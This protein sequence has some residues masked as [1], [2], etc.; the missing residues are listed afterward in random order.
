MTAQVFS[1]LR[2]FAAPRDWSAQELAEFYRVESALIQAG[3]QVVSARGLTD[4]DEPWFVF[5][6][7]EDDEVIIHFARIDGRYVISAPAYCGN[8]VGHDFRAL[9]RKVIERHPVLQPRPSGD[10]LFLHPAALLV[11]LVASALLKSGHAA[12]AASARQTAADTTGDKHRNV[13][14]AVGP[15]AVAASEPEAQHEIQ[16]LAA[17]TAATAAPVQAEPV[18]IVVSASVHLA[19]FIDQ[20]PEQPV[21]PASLDVAG[22]AATHGSGG[23]IQT[24]ATLQSITTPQMEAPPS[25]LA[26]T[27]PH[28]GCPRSWQAEEVAFLMRDQALTCA[29]LDH[30]ASAA[31]PTAA[32]SA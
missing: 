4:E 11:M 2:R 10:N 5:C 20:S 15:A 31:L 6:R 26:H 29:C 9:V 21:R 16:I 23:V 13:L 25:W 18:T 22:D 8:A 28:S 7:A 24:V 14:P 17:I 12:E 32:Q 19:D 27:I 3:L 1:F 30:S